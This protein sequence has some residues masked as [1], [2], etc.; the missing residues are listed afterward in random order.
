M[1]AASAVTIIVLI[2]FCAQT[3]AR[4]YNKAFNFLREFGYL[5]SDKSVS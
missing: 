4:D 1:Q 3:N 2:A 5:E